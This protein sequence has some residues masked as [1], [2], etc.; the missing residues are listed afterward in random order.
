VHST[1][2]DDGAD[3]F[4]FVVGAGNPKACACI[5]DTVSNA[6]TRLNL[7]FSIRFLCVLYL[8][9]LLCFVVVADDPKACACIEDTVGTLP[10]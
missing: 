6:H 10:I 5:E 1:K 7:V 9:V 2:E 4:A 3:G 8:Y